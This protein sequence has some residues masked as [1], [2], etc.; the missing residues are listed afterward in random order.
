M[1][2]DYNFMY[3][4]RSSNFYMYSEKSDSG[5][6]GGVHCHNFYE[7]YYLEEGQRDWLIG[8]NNYT[9]S[10]GYF[11]L[12]KP[13]ILHKSFAGAFTRKLAYFSHDF[14]RKYISPSVL[15]D[16]LSVFDTHVI[17]PSDDF[18]DIISSYWKAIENFYSKEDGNG[19]A[20]AVTALMCL[21]AEYKDIPLPHQGKALIDRITDYVEKNALSIN[22]I[23]EISEEFG[24]NKYYM[25]HLF[26]KEKEMGVY[27]FLS[28]LKVAHASYELMTTE[29]KVRDIAYEC[30]FESEYYFSKRFKQIV[31]ISPSEYRKNLRTKEEFEIE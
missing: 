30:G 9:V 18:V 4:F 20:F 16:I 2:K 7:I 5:D 25:C 13:H 1:E 11:V 31:S 28:M 15:E 21:L 17:I 12:V 22:K 24:I 10:K 29:K 23:D 6:M 3:E 19:F 27:D 26:Q 14:I 8:K